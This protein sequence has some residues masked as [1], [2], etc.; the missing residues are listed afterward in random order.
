[1]ES[2]TL[3]SFCIP[4]MY[5]HEAAVRTYQPTITYFKLDKSFPSVL[6]SLMDHQRSIIFCQMW[7][8]SL[9]KLQTKMAAQPLTS[10]QIVSC[11]W[12]VSNSRWM[13]FCKQIKS[14]KATFV[15]I[16]TCM[17]WLEKR[18]DLMEK[19]LLLA[20]GSADVASKRLLQIEQYYRL[21]ECSDGA[22]VMLDLRSS[23]ELTGNFD[24]VEVLM[25]L[26]SNFMFLVLLL[27]SNL[28]ANI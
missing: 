19:E 8:Q 4:C 25:N 5:T 7:S 10:A 18:R 20:C 2:M 26:V 16:E 9:L 11:V 22:K 21:S 15:E 14:A 13:L 28:I 1:M 3:D 24:L 27:P 12:E 17:D 23:F 6:E